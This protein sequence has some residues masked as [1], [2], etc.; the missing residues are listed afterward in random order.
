M[1]GKDWE[2]KRISFDDFKQLKPT[3]PFKQVPVLEVDGKVIPQSLAQLRYV[4]KIG[5]IYPEDALEAANADAAMDAVTDLHAR[6][7]P[8]VQAKDHDKKLELRKD[9]VEYAALWLGNLEHFLEAAG[10]KYFAGGKLSIGD[11]AVVARLNWLKDGTL[12]AVPTTIVDGYPLLSALVD[13]VMS[14]PRIVDYVEKLPEP[15]VRQF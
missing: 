14:E 12:E 10:G 11:I 13:R 9:F 3:L 6:L 1:T 8:S 5:G 2:D 15:V 7:A 4:G